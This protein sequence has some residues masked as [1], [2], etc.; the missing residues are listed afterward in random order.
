MWF[1]QFLSSYSLS[2]F[3]EFC[4]FL[5]LLICLGPFRAS[6][7]SY[8]NSFLFLLALVL[9]FFFTNLLS[10]AYCTLYLSVLFAFYRNSFIFI[11]EHSIFASP[12]IFLVVDF[13]VLFCMVSIDF[14]RIV[15]LFSIVGSSSFKPSNLWFL[16]LFWREW[17]YFLTLSGLTFEC[18]LFG[19]FL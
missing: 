11:S 2:L 5:C 4:L 19:D 8:I 18:F 14:A 13:C 16:I 15:F 17:L 1:L 12:V 10:S 6:N 3:I 7:V 9:L